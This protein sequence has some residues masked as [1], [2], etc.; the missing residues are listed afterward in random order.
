MVGCTTFPHE[1]MLELTDTNA[2]NISHSDLN[3]ILIVDKQ[4]AIRTSSQLPWRAPSN[5]SHQWDDKPPT[6]S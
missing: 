1:N 3:H 5:H 4:L 6:T 2:V